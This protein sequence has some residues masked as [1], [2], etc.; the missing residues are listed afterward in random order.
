M[1]YFVLSILCKFADFT[2][3]GSY[4]LPKEPKYW[5]RFQICHKGDTFGISYFDERKLITFRKF[6]E[7]VGN[8]NKALS[9]FINSLFHQ[10]AA[11]LSRPKHA[12][13]RDATIAK[14]ELALSLLLR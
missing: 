1:H 9:H 6:I 5:M 7:S 11:L 2:F 4:R 8:V 3:L 14:M 12:K 10:T 13:N